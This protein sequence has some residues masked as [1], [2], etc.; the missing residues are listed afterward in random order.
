LPKHFD[1]VEKTRIVIVEYTDGS[2]IKYFD[3]QPEAAFLQDTNQR[4]NRDFIAARQNYQSEV[5][6]GPTST[7]ETPQTRR[8]TE[9]QSQT[10]LD[11]SNTPWGTPIGQEK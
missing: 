10:K 2:V 6:S 7:V 8:A 3:V 1:Y 4:K 5:V 11:L 9:Q